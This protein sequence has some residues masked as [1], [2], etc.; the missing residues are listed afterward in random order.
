VVNR[1]DSR[2]DPSYMSLLQLDDE[3]VIL[4]SGGK[5]LVLDPGEKMCP[6]GVVNWKHSGVEGLRQG[7]DGPSRA[8]T[9]QQVFSIN[10]VR[11]E[12]DLTL[13][14]HGGVRGTIEIVMT[15]QAA[16]FWRQVA[17]QN[18]SSGLKKQF[19]EELEGIVPEGVEARLDHFLEL[20]QPD[21]ALMAMVRVKGTLAAATAKRLI[22]PGFFFES[23]ARLPFV[24]EEKREEPVDMHYPG[25]T[26]DQIRYTLPA[27]ATVEG[28]PQD[29][30]SAWQ[31]RTALDAAEQARAQYV[32][33]TKIDPG[34]ITAARVLATTFT[35]V[36]P[37]EYLGLRGFYQKAAAADQEQI[38]LSAPAAK[39]N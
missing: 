31:G 18:D 19:D 11:R 16:L 29:N 38:V 15:G 2:F 21:R 24:N 8:R 1:D 23:R 7:A 35:A 9:P 39:G 17:L 5:E 36:P 13:D 6:F 27:G 34:Q 25:R 37:E 10:T 33:K 30:N 32:T 20:D 26:T 12:G 22:L 28:M 14:E 4:S 3:V